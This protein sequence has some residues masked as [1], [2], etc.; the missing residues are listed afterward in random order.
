MSGIAFQITGHSTMDSIAHLGLYFTLWRWGGGGGE[1]PSVA[2]GF[3]SQSVSHAESASM[4]FHP[5][6][7]QLSMM[8]SPNGSIFRVTG[9]LCGEITSH[10]WIPHKGQWRR[11]LMFSLICVWINGWVNNRHMTSLG[12]NEL[13]PIMPSNVLQQLEYA[14]SSKLSIYSISYPRYVTICAWLLHAILHME[15]KPPYLIPMM[16]YH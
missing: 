2:G 6:A 14:S 9:P 4:S 3:P 1:Y 12:H 8:T 13:I 16:H 15:N 7:S 11:A 10:R 5:H